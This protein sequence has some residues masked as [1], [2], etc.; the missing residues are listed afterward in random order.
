LDLIQN[1]LELRRDLE[2]IRFASPVTHVYNPLCYAWEPHR[3]YL[4]RYGRA[5]REVLLVGMNPGPWGMAQTGV[6]FG[7]VEL[8]RDWLRIEGSVARPTTEHPRRPVQGF[9]CRRREGSGRRLWGWARDRFGTPEAFFTRFFVGNYCP[10]CFFLED[11]T[12]LTPDK[13]PSVQRREL[14]TTCDR[15]LA[16]MVEVLQPRFVL[17]VGRFAERRV[18]KVLT[19][20][21]AVAGGVPHPSP[22][23]P[24]ANR[25]WAGQMEAALR[26]VGIDLV[27]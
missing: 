17:G 3:A 20:G 7:D 8:V 13:L 23:S 22:A 25:G 18:A 19:G 16:Q 26:A 15:G 27:P 1:A 21:G 5:P 6:P 9:A 10:L 11:G 14:E 24:S 2:R 4:E 12:N